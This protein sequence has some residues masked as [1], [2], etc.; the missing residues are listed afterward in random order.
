MSRAL[1]VDFG[2]RRVGLSLSDE[3][4][5]IAQPFQTL[6][7]R[8]DFAAVAR[9]LVALA[10]AQE[11]TQLV[12]GWPLRLNGKEGLQTRRVERF[13]E[14]IERELE[15]VERPTPVALW[16]E[17]LSTTAA[18]R[19]LIEGGVGRRARREVVDQVAASVILQ[20]WLD[21]QRAQRAYSESQ[22]ITN[23]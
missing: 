10:E 22:E 21:A 8:G 2:A 15:R 11:V 14:A 20:G 1:G 19:A 5:L 12:V 23:T 16:D 18:E 3:G 9:E 4:R 6:P 7:N 13:V 17:R